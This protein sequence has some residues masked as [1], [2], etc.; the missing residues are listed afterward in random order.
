MF[1]CSDLVLKLAQSLACKEDLRKFPKYAVLKNML[2]TCQC[3]DLN[4]AELV[5]L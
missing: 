1:S 2:Q 4:Q 5:N 3:G